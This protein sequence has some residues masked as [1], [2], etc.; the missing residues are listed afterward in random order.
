MDGGGGEEPMRGSRGS[1][2]LWLTALCGVLLG[3]GC[4]KSGDAPPLVPEPEQNGGQGEEP[5][6]EPDPLEEAVC[7]PGP[8]PIRRMTRR[9]YNNS[10]RE[11]LGD[12]TSPANAFPSEEEGLGFTNNAD[13]QS[14]SPVLAE[15]Y[16]VVAE[17]VATR[18][19]QNLQRLLP[20]KP[21]EVGE[22]ACALEFI[23]KMGR[24][25][26]RRPL[27]QADVDALFAA[28]TSGRT[29]ADFRTGIERVLQ[30]ILQSPE[31]LY[32]V[33]VGEPVAD[34]EGVSALDDWEIAS[35][36]SFLL[37]GSTPD[38]EL[39]KAAEAGALSTADEVAAQ[40]RR[41]LADPRARETVRE[42]HAQWLGLSRIDTLVKDSARYPKFTPSIRPHLRAEVDAFLDHVIWE[43]DGTLKTLFT[44]PYTFL[45]GTLANY[46]GLP[47]PS[48]TGMVKVE[49]PAGRASGLFTQGGLM[50]SLSTPNQTSPILR[51]KFVRERLL[52]QTIPPPPDGIPLLAPD[53]DP[54]L[55][56]RERMAIHRQQPSCN[57]CHMMMDPI[58]FGFEKF[59]GV[60]RYRETEVGGAPVDDSGEVVGREIGAFRGIPDLA[61]RLAKDP[62]VHGCFVK[63]WFRFALGRSETEADACTLSQLETTFSSSGGNIQELLIALT[64]TD[65]FRFRSTPKD[66]KEGDKP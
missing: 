14:V 12:T 33:E 16:M 21:A 50:A 1:R 65:A 3:G 53:P 63:N 60:G 34:R 43:G 59:D 24:R 61:G 15:H 28:Y 54:K 66:S 8:S 35:R 7:A 39:L 26:F 5:T 45:N 40:A 25:A 62:E 52:C 38:E 9:E 46:Y 27:A 4:S 22:K 64:R 2:G 36:L 18:A 42:F 30:V 10:V 48:G 56:A 49:L 37:W 17:Q 19:T 57:G 20:C 6:K 47:S 31:F 41:M 55:T 29:G 23:Q 32:R 13:M 11:L 51:G 44:A 58:G